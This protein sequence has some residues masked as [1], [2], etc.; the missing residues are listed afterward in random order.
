MGAP[1]RAGG[2]AG[3][4]GALLTKNLLLR[5][6]GA[7]C[8]CSVLE[9]VLPVL[10]FLVMCV[11]R[12]ITD[13]LAPEDNPF[14]VQYP[15]R[16]MVPA[17]LPDIRWG[18]PDK[19]YCKY[20][21]AGGAGRLGWDYFA[22]EG[23]YKILH[24]RSAP[25]PSDADAIVEAAVKK[26]LCDKSS[27]AFSLGKLLKL[28][29]L[30]ELPSTFPYGNGSAV[31]SS[32]AITV[33]LE[34]VL[35]LTH[36]TQNKRQ[37]FLDVVGACHT[38]ASVTRRLRQ[39]LKDDNFEGDESL[40]SLDNL[41]I[42]QSEFEDWNRSG[43]V[44][45]GEEICTAECL[46]DQACYRPTLD[47]FLLG[48][49]SPGEAEEYVRA[50]EGE[51]M[52]VIEFPADIGT[53][54]DPSYLLRMNGT[55][56]AS[57]DRSF[58]NW[59][60]G[61]GREPWMYK[62]HYPTIN[63][64]NAVD[65]ALVNFRLNG[66]DLDTFT[67]DFAPL[68]SGYPIPA[69]SEDNQGQIAGWLFAQLMVIAFLPTVILQM[70]FLVQE[71]ELRLREGMLIMGL[72]SRTYWAGHFI[73]VYIPL[74]VLSVIVG[75]I[76]AYTFPQSDP[77]VIIVYMLIWLTTITF[78]CAML[79]TVFTR[80]TI[81]NVVGAILYLV[82]QVPGVIATISNLSG[83]SAWMVA[84]VFPASGI[85]MFGQVLANFESMQTGAQ[86]S[87]VTLNIAARG[88]SSGYISIAGL[89]L[90]NVCMSTWYL[91]SLWYLEQVWP[92]SIGPRR[93]LWFLFLPS[94]WCPTWFKNET[95]GTSFAWPGED[96]PV[97]SSP[98]IEKGSG[99]PSIVLRG[100]QK[101]FGT[102]DAVKGLSTEMYPDSVTVLLGHN[103][104]GKT[105]TLSMLVGLFP[106]TSGVAT[107]SGKDI[108]TSMPE[109]RQRCGFCP[110]FDILWP[111]LTVKEHLSF[112]SLFKGVPRGSIGAE[113]ESMVARLDL[114]AQTNQPAGQL[115]GGQRRRLSLGI[116][117]L[118][119]PDT[120][121][122]DEPTSGMDP[123]ARRHAWSVIAAAKRGKT[124]VLTTHFMDEAD[125]LGDR[126]AIMSAGKIFASG[127]S[128]FLK[129]KFGVGYRV[130][131]DT[132]RSSTWGSMSNLPPAE[133]QGAPT[134]QMMDEEAKKTQVKI[135][136]LIQSI[137]PSTRLQNVSRS[138][139]VFMLPQAARLEFP[140]LV[141]GISERGDEIGVRSFGISCTTMEEVF[142][143][144]KKCADAQEL[145]ERLNS[146]VD[147]RTRKTFDPQSLQRTSLR[148]ETLSRDFSAARATPAR[149]FLHLVQK[150]VFCSIGDWQAAITL[151]LVPV[152]FWVLALAILAVKPPFLASTEKVQWGPQYIN[153]PQ[154]S[155]P[156]GA[157]LDAT[158][159]PLY[160]QSWQPEPVQLEPI[161]GARGAA[162]NE[163]LEEF[164]LDLM[165][166][167]EKA[168]ITQNC[169]PYD[170]NPFDTCTAYLATEPQVFPPSNGSNAG[171]TVHSPFLVM[172]QMAMHSPPVALNLANEGKARE[173]LG[174]DIESLRVD[175][176]I[177][178]RG[179]ETSSRSQ[180]VLAN[181]AMLCAGVAL[182]CIGASFSIF[183]SMEDR[184]N[185]KLLQMVSGA[186]KTVFWLASYVFDICLYLLPLGLL[187]GL[188]AAMPMRKFFMW[189]DAFGGC[190]ILLALFGPA[191]ISQAYLLSLPFRNEMLCF[192]VLFVVYVVV[193]L[194]TFEVTVMLSILG[195]QGVPGT[196]EALQVLQ[197]VFPVVPQF[198]AVKSLYDIL[199]NFFL[200]DVPFL[201][202]KS[203]WALPNFSMHLLYMAVLSVV[204]ISLVVF[205]EVAQP[206]LRNRLER[207][208]P[209][210][211]GAEEESKIDEDVLAEKKRIEDDS[212]VTGVLTLRGL[213]KSFTR[214]AFDHCSL[215]STTKVAVGGLNLGL[216]EGECFGLLGVNGAGKTTTFRILAGDLAPTSGDILIKRGDQPVS[217]LENREDFNKMIGYCPQYGGLFERMTVRQH[218]AFYVGIRGIPREL[219]LS[220]GKALMD[221]LNISQYADRQ[222]RA[223]SGGNQRKLS[224]ALALIGSPTLVLLDE[225]STGM[226]PESRR[227]L[228]E[229]IRASS[230]WRTVVLT[231][232]S[233]E[234][235]EALCQSLAIMVNGQFR[236]LG[237]IQH[238]KNRFGSGYSV[239]LRA[240]ENRS[241]DLGNFMSR[242][243]PH[244][245]L[246]E[247][248]GLDM[249]YTI[250]REQ[251][252]E[253]M[254][255]LA[256]TFQKLEDKGDAVGL[257]EYSISQTM[258][259]EV[260]L[261]FAHEQEDQQT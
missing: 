218:I 49:A 204:Q 94:F 71:K 203:V 22:F 76:G 184:M 150:R 64:Q 28:E 45:I 89:M 115:S 196:I 190:V 229:V 181:I 31:A 77:S 3:R 90:I 189:G 41:K 32:D 43:V 258:L 96:Q 224:V 148:L 220:V 149:Q 153:S 231:S 78:F 238:L 136:K 67:H 119:S 201:G 173:L 35:G 14:K 252:E 208:P 7:N 192:G 101:R 50:H 113:I 108:R 240:K 73:T 79:S 145:S 241:S 230:K 74:I 188:L 159:P 210:L 110:Q 146:S 25:E 112:F 182:S 205:F 169:G 124:I 21:P 60:I 10:F 256:D 228:W 200:Y 213:R 166:N 40:A 106:P 104:A 46:G 6:R 245:E 72:A 117:M 199:V 137:V 11:P 38:W 198:A 103:G 257:E 82:S 111:T 162:L 215:R 16:Q 58:V 164:Q 130:T 250:S 53:T 97:Q 80:T 48:V 85:Y 19:N 100:L 234:E 44:K 255:L 138:E 37:S 209:P 69:Y 143:N 207:S 47:Q 227:N 51:V 156:Y 248:H 176:Q 139:L 147:R 131:I 216:H 75:G 187:L 261:H 8:A 152:L 249:R 13:G 174:S 42:V 9:I 155:V 167:R 23:A 260:F 63:I 92:S 81:A 158:P 18:F 98:F 57:L 225:P 180:R 160:G 178:P 87:S 120:V 172:N 121:F 223:L 27:S 93:P 125:I 243:L 33:A 66:G 83:S 191:A 195:N 128:L 91:F 65:T 118:G 20:A 95:E 122:L 185:A 114:V 107:I 221:S 217:A 99:T 142:M 171:V 154:K 86:W 186:N 232:H 123:A 134:K 132:G 235:C 168:P 84:G 24:V 102:F 4:L 246:A 161:R 62:G 259:E 135:T 1:P 105:T 2:E 144:T 202:S 126:I 212:D 239:H 68:I 251:M 34:N 15:D 127:S 194:I 109:I 236:C 36:F 70:N 170:G 116:A 219:G 233:M 206:V 56:F 5:Q 254:G 247:A 39:V 197:Y 141:R 133:M 151:L 59:A 52:A 177:L 26:L 183:P 140:S 61:K 157:V 244:A 129:S 165:S 29:D 226:D 211:A 242:E 237:N 175:F 54:K 17:D 88:E 163:T 222:A 55:D 179:A 193:V 30:F 253:G 214:R 12:L